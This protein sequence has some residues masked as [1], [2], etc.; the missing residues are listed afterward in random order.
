MFYV[1]N[2]PHLDFLR[3]E[4]IVE[5]NYPMTCLGT[6][7]WKR[8]VGK[9]YVID[10]NGNQCHFELQESTRL[11]IDNDGVKSVGKWSATLAD[12]GSMGVPTIDFAANAET[13]KSINRK[14]AIMLHKDN[15]LV[16]KLLRKGVEVNNCVFAVRCDAI[17][18]MMKQPANYDE[19]TE[20]IKTLVC[21]HR[22]NCTIW[23]KVSRLSLAPIF[24]VIAHLVIFFA[25]MFSPFW[26]DW[27]GLFPDYTVRFRGSDVRIGVLITF[28]LLFVSIYLSLNAGL[29]AFMERY[30]E[31]CKRNRDVSVEEI[32][33]L[34]E[35]WDLT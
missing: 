6:D 10:G 34:D 2:Y 8:L 23:W 21:I 7:A 16:L 19:V 27:I 20:Y 1:Y 14:Y 11:L 35:E 29:K 4:H 17:E 28:T 22:R 33:D 5:A 25:L 32:K 3:D 9:Y 31:R 30:K 12:V 13:G 18:N 15:L 24:V 26:S